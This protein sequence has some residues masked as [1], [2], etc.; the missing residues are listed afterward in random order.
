MRSYLFL[1]LFAG[2]VATAVL[3]IPTLL[4]DDT[5]CSGSA[6]H[7][8]YQGTSIVSCPGGGCPPTHP[9]C[10]LAMR[11]EPNGHAFLQCLCW[12]TYGQAVGSGGSACVGVD[13]LDQ[14]GNWVQTHC[15]AIA[16]DMECCIYP[17][18]SVESPLCIC[19]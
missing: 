11:V 7:H 10:A 19:Q 15:A 18:G 4:V 14:D 17:P 5:S 9:E 1:L 8:G 6:T 16:C 13:E 12:N 2:F 3:G